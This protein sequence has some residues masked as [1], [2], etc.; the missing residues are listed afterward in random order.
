M[1]FRKLIPIFILATLTAEAR[2]FPL[3]GVGGTAEMPFKV[4][5]KNSEALACNYFGLELEKS[6]NVGRYDGSMSTN[7]LRNNIIYCLLIYKTPHP[8]GYV[9]QKFFSVQG[10]ITNGIWEATPER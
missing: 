6:Y 5:T 9:S 3:P 10:N 4:D 1:K 2:E 7:M 8:N